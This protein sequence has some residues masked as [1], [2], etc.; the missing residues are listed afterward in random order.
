[1]VAS[2]VLEVVGRL[3]QA[4][5]RFW[6]EG[7]WGVDALLGRST[8]PHADLD[9]AVV[10]AD[11]DAAQRALEP[12]DLRHDPTVEPGRPARLVLRDAHGRQV[13]VHP[14]VL[15]ARGNGWQRLPGGAWGLYAGDGL[16]GRGEI[17]GRPVRCITA[18]LQLRHRLGYAWGETDRHDLRLL[19]ERFDV[20][21][22]PE[23]P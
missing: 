4:G 17:D 9:L 18:E 14:I 19:A 3:E 8:R 7:G 10:E 15:D 22:P 6:L 16:R 12:L 1:M 5:V 13:D 20:P 23:T 21:L 11:C 2:D